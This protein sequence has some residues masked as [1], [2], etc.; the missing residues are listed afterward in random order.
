MR[1]S[2]AIG[3]AASCVVLTLVA[4][5]SSSGSKKTG[6]Q[7][8]KKSS[9]TQTF[10]VNINAGGTPKKG[11]TLHILGT[12]DVDYMDP[13]VSYYSVGY[14][15]LRI[16][17][18]QLVTFPAVVGK[19]TTVVPDIATQIPTASNGGVTDG[20]KTVK[21][22]IKTGVKWDTTPARQVTAAD[23]VRGMKRTCN[24]AEPFG[25]MP[26]FE[27]LIVGL[28]T[29]CSGFAKVNPKSASAIAAYQN[30]HDLPGVSVDPSNPLTVVYKLTSPASYFTD[31]LAMPAFSPS[32][33]EYD[34]YIPASAD[35]AQHT[36]ADGPYKVA[37]YVP[38]K[39]ISFVRNP[40]WS[41]STDT[42][43]KAYVN[44][45]DVSE[46]GNQDSIQTQMQANSPGADM[47]WDTF[48]PNTDVPSLIAK[49]DPNLNV[50]PQFGTNPYLVFNTVSPNN[51]GALKNAAVRQA[52]TRGINREH[53]TVDLSGPAVSPPLTHILPAGISG[54]T[55]NTSPNPYPYDAAQSKKDLASA[56]QKNLTIK[57]LYRSALSDSKA[58]YLTL[59]Q[60]LSKIGV[61][62]VGVAATNAD[63][64]TKYLEVPS[65]AKSGTWD[66]AITSW[67]PDWYGDAARSFFAPLFYGNGG[68]TGSA[69]PPSG[70]DFGFYN[71]AQVN[72]LTDEASAQSSAAA[73]SKLW[74]QADD[75]VTKDAAIYPITAPN[76]P[77]Y[78]ATHLHNTVPIPAYQQPDPTNVWLASS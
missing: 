29:Y 53:L 26:D 36:I 51:G 18:R 66:V 41:A 34:K 44:A 54:T 1:R 6:Q 9:T 7:S 59:Q 69:F 33:K 62:V 52:L 47:E 31:M 22:T 10:P 72:K 37:Q 50:T 28:Q 16:W 5:C 20:G 64:F 48:P 23:E 30:S 14:L 76:Q 17:S 70:S 35:L 71:N 78:H 15:G 46:T 2:P 49:K 32:P 77:N 8:N 45:I 24:P 65:V 40:A 63:F 21:L 25:G 74:V 73:A 4:G 38:T 58:I 56:G 3:I 11:G 75:I 55:N 60:D 61:K 67:G 43:R 19:T 13:N 39:S 27:S 68:K 42:V 57:V 12:S